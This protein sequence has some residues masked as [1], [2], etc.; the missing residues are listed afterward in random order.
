MKLKKK[1][2]H[3]FS[4]DHVYCLKCGESR[5]TTTKVNKPT[6]KMKDKELRDEFEK[7]FD[8]YVVKIDMPHIYPKGLEVELKEHNKNVWSWIE[9]ALQAKEEEIV[10]RIDIIMDERLEDFVILMDSKG[11]DIMVEYLLVFKKIRKDI[12]ASLKK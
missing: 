9:K 5:V 7:K 6:T 12:V 8:D 11:V 2:E 10:E 3:A 1:C 4:E